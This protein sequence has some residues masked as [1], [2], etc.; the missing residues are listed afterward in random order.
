MI[1]AHNEIATQRTAENNVSPLTSFYRTLITTIDDVPYPV[2]KFLGT[3]YMLGNET[4]FHNNNWLNQ[5]IEELFNPIIGRAI[6][7]RP[8]LARIR[9]QPLAFPDAQLV[10]PYVLSFN[11]SDTNVLAMIAL[12]ENISDFFKSSKLATKTLLQIGGEAAGITIL[13]HSVEPP[14]LP[15]WHNLPASLTQP[16]TFRS[17]IQFAHDT[18]FMEQKIIGDADLHHPTAAQCNPLLA[19]VVA[20]NCTPDN[21]T[22]PADTFQQQY[23][24]PPVMYFQPYDRATS[25][26]NYTITLGIK[27]ESGE[28]DG[29]T[30]PT[31][32]VF[33]SLIDTNS[34]YLQGS[35]PVRQCYNCYF[36]ENF[37][38][39]L[40]RRIPH[41]Q[42]HD[43]KGLAIV[44]MTRNILPRFGNR[45]VVIPGPILPGFDVIQPVHRPHDA[46]TYTAS[47][48]IN[49]Y[50]VD[51]KRFYLWSS[52]RYVPDP[53]VLAPRV[54]F[55]FTLRGMYGTCVTLARSENP[56][57][58]LPH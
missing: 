55:F 58:L 47:S 8:S 53:T 35:I 12:I 16:Q 7:N 42:M 36:T 5:A 29:V 27:I 11:Y 20:S 2:N 44:D 52:Y 31:P 32:N 26:L 23:T 24:Y 51:T 10:N 13:S 50:P 37:P 15:T 25:T 30:I 41:D 46:F 28:L 57:R 3:N 9:V 40:S 1:A 34:R 54:H 19:L 49:N 21:E 14:T 17:D 56:A 4:C 39:V 43:P 33:D 6:T 38:L 45:H 22:F 48:G 18:H